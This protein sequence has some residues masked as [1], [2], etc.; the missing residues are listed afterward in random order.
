MLPTGFDLLDDIVRYNARKP[1]MHFT[2]FPLGK[3]VGLEADPVASYMQR[4]DEVALVIAA[5]LN[6]R[7]RALI[8]YPPNLPADFFDMNTDTAIRILQHMWVCRIRLALVIAPGTLT[9]SDA[10]REL[11]FDA[12]RWRSVGLFSYRTDALEWLGA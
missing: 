5:C 1:D 3:A 6:A 2:P 8:L 4:A 11:L 7:A 10:F 12:Q 9:I